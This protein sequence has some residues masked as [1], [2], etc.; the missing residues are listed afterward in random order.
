MSNKINKTNKKWLF[1][2]TLL[3]SWISAD[4]EEEFQPLLLISTMDFFPFLLLWHCFLDVWLMNYEADVLWIVI[5]FMP[6]IFSYPTHCFGCHFFSREYGL[7]M[8]KWDQNL[9][10]A[11]QRLWSLHGTIIYSVVQ[12]HCTPSGWAA[13]C[14]GETLE[15][16]SSQPAPCYMSVTYHCSLLIGFLVCHLTQ[17]LW[18]FLSML[19]NP[20]PNYILSC[21]AVVSWRK[22]SSS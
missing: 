8:F 11:V 14:W 13:C 10:H 20:I 22:C 6:F 4:E 2:K 3:P 17:K 15:W 1:Q 16:L 5:P 9:L 19:Q 18:H 7:A 12:D 21:P